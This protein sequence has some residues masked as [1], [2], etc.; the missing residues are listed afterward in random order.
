MAYQKIKKSRKPTKTISG[1]TPLAVVIK[2]QKCP[3]GTCV[4]CPSL[5]APQSYTP[6]SPAIMRAILFDYDP[7]KQVKSRLKAFEMMEHSTN[8]I[9]LIV[10]GGTFLSYPL[11]YQY[12]FI[13]RC[14]DSLNNKTSKTLKDAK[15]LNEHAKHRCI[16]LCIET[17]PDICGKKEI[18][19]ML[20]FGATRCELGVQ[21]LDDKIYKKIKRGHTVKDVIDATKRLKDAGFK[22]GYH[23]M[24]NLPYSNMKHDIAMFEKMFLDENFRP[25]QLK[26]YPTQV[27]QGSEL[28]N[29]FKKGKFVPYQDNQ[30]IN[31]L[32]KLKTKVPEYCRIMRIMREI[33]P[34]YL[35]AGTFKTDLRKIVR[36]EMLKRKL[37]C[38]CIRCREVGFALR[39]R[40]KIDKTI[41]LKTIRYNASG[42]KEFF[43]SFVN[44]DDIIFGLCRIRIINNHAM[45]RELHV[46][47]P[48]VEIG[49]KSEKEKQWQHKGLGKRL[50]EEAEKIAKD[51]GC[52]KI[53]VISGVGVRDYYKKIG[54]KLE[55]E[56]MV[57]KLD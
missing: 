26:I 33:P 34:E 50:M 35:V 21:I 22:V 47:G 16:A 29:L 40:K 48:Q 54:Y 23:V 10:M 13:K 30:L 24:P 36:E 57:K 49:E 15:K 38:K 8:K 45:I 39:E 14:Y 53:Y 32:I 11:E 41:N 2:P 27:I 55:K 3:H 9:E 52:K 25:D 19:R 20:E 6:K 37:E 5:D 44:K 4:Y 46:F 43:L 17:R 1:V 28:E 31:L 56:Y 12:N 7:Y 42:G 18:E 51:N